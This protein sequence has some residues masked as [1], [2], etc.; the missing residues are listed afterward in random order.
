[1]EEVSHRSFEA[2]HYRC[3]EV[4]EL[5]NPTVLARADAVED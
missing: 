3:D 2:L 4:H 1:M 5:T